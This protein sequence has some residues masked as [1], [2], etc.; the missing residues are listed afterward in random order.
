MLWKS[1]YNIIAVPVLCVGFHI[2][3]K[4]NTKVRELIVGRQDILAALTK[5]LESAR[6][7]DRTVWFHFASVGEF[8]Q[9]QPLIEAIRDDV[10]IVLTYFSPSVHVNVA[11]YSNCDAAVYLPLDT[12]RNAQTLIQIIKPTLLIF[13][14][15]DIWQDFFLT[16]TQ[17]SR[18][19][20]RFLKNLPS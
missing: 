2:A 7:L 16:H 1:L 13:S 9:A 15:F 6:K 8:E 20:P 3:A 11:R 19:S 18:I 14:K 17:M 4:F 5:Q 12:C 10:R